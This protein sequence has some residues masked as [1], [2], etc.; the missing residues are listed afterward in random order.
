VAM[1]R[2]I[3]Q[4]PEVN[5]CSETPWQGGGKMKWK[6]GNRPV[7]AGFGIATAILVSVG[8]Q[9]YRNTADSLRLAQWREHTYEVLNSLDN[10]VGRLSDAETGQRGY[11]LTGKRPT[12]SRTVRR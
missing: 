1:S 11:L 4:G 6:M 9:S 7:L 2:C 10:A 5:A 8:W 12:S 3:R